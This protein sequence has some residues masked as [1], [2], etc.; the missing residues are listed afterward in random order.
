MKEYVKYHACIEK[1]L[2]E[3]PILKKFLLNDYSLEFSSNLIN[4][5]FGYEFAEYKESLTADFLNRLLTELDK[6]GEIKCK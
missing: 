5:Y 3:Y 4:K 6:R 2:E 1:M